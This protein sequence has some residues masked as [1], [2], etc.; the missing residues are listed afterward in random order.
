KLDLL[1]IDVEAAGD[2]EVLGAAD[3]MNVAALIDR[4]DVAG[5]EEAVLAEFRG[6]LLR[7]APVA[8][9]DVRP[10]RLEHSD[11]A[12]RQRLPVLVG[13]AHLDVGQGKAHRA[14]DALAP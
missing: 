6:C 9:E 5:D 4:R 3:D 2:D 14:G 12:P 1:R 11:R 10:L 13:N 7:L 8:A